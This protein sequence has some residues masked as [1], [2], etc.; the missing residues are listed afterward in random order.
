MYR[1]CASCSAKIG[2]DLCK[3]ALNSEFKMME[4]FKISLVDSNEVRI[5]AVVF[6]EEV[7]KYIMEMKEPRVVK[8]N[9]RTEFK[10]EKNS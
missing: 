1:V 8:L 2:D 5:T 3:C 6:D 9:V 7:Q 4:Y 10:M